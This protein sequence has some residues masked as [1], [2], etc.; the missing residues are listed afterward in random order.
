MTIQELY[1]IFKTHPIVTTDSRQITE[2][3]LFFAL[4]GDNFDGNTF[5]Q[6]AL[7]Q[8]A[9]YAVVDKPE[10]ALSDRCILVND[11]LETLQKL[12]TFHRRHFDF[13]VIAITGS[14]GKTTTKELIAAVM[15]GRYNTHFTKGNF[16]NHI[17]VPLTLL[18]LDDSH[19]VAI[20]E[21]GANHIGEIDF[22]TRIAEPTHGLIT[23]IGKAH[24][25]G[26]GSLEGVKI[27]KSELY[28][29]LAKH[30]KTIFVNEEEPFL[31]ALVPETAHKILYKKSDAPSKEVPQYEVALN[32]TE[33]FLT[34]TF[35][36]AHGILHTVKSN[37]IGVYNFNNLMTAIAVGKYFK[38]P[39][40]KIQ[41]TLE[42]YV[43][44]MNR[45][46]IIKLAQGATLILDAYNANPSSMRAALLN[47]AQM[48]HAHKMAILGDMRE[49]GTQSD[50]EH[51]D[52]LA[53][54]DSLNFT[55]L[56]TVGASFQKLR[57]KKDAEFS[58]PDNISAKNWLKTQNFT[59][60]TCILLKGSRGLKL[61]V[62]FS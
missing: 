16:N 31:S 28:R 38:V 20:I 40:E 37:L 26:F 45:S 9:A 49:L 23:N 54:A 60:D 50:Q 41:S 55:K 44:N 25:E 61:E 11:V 17:G 47:L 57:T 33:P 58:F 30:H 2:G 48:P 36:S 7:N 39:S 42:N 29:W 6:T 62:L 5:A 8:G 1:D 53:L 12:A 14:N 59:A 32:A 13:P 15:S 3:C 10:F 4:R 43:P 19:E 24:L 35:L 34:V 56:V 52:I 22:L 27:G 51:R 18:Q 21:M 46:Q